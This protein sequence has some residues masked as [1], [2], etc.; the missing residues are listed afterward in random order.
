MARF[1]GMALRP[2]RSLK[3]IIDSNG[4]VS[5]A[6]QSINDVIQAVDDP[7][8]I[9]GNPQQVHIGSTVHGIFL[10]VQVIQGVAAGGVDNIYLIVLKNPGN[11]LTVPNL[12]AVGNDD[13]RKHVIH[14]EMI[15]TGNTGTVAS[16]IPKTLFKGVIKIPPR[17]KRFGV[18]D[19]LQVIMQHRT[20]ESTQQTDFCLQCIYKEFS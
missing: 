19:R 15:M 13:N 14:Q 9:T 18:Q 7:A 6:G 11:N 5:A 16:A 1:R 17:L 8:A 10:N 12:D 2:V 4:I 3:H 20:G